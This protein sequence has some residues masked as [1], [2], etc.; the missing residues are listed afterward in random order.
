M[1]RILH[2]NYFFLVTPIALGLFGFVYP[3]L[4]LFSA[5]T[6]IFTG[7]FQIIQA[8]CLFIDKDF[9]SQALTVY[10]TVAI[11]F[12]ILWIN[13]SWQRTWAMPPLL[14]IYLTVILFIEAKNEKS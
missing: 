5:I 1:K 14:A 10:F 6:P 11:L 9:K 3:S 12:F 4:W 7:F 13:T 8:I 2:L